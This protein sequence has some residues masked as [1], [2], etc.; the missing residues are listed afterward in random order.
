V[1]KLLG[2][3][4]AWDNAAQVHSG[5]VAG[6]AH[7]QGQVLT[8]VRMAVRD[9]GAWSAVRDYQFDYEPVPDG[10]PDTVSP[11]RV[12][13]TQMRECVEPIDGNGNIGLSTCFPPTR[14]DWSAAAPAMQPL[15][16]YAFDG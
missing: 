13:L 11:D 1:Q 15:P 2:P 10:V 4:S 9:A 6:M 12:R 14:F 5:Y 16:G 3:V 8:T 7:R